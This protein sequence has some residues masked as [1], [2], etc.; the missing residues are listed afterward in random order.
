MHGTILNFGFCNGLY[1]IITEP[2]I[3]LPHSMPTHLTNHHTAPS[4]LTTT[5]TTAYL[6]TPSPRRGTPFENYYVTPIINQ[7]LNPRVCTAVDKPHL[8]AKTDCSE[9]LTS[10]TVGLTQNSAQRV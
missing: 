5:S 6:E 3:S 9:Q 7:P 4:T 1:L 2:C 8:N 10:V